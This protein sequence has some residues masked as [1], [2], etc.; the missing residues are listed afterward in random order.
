MLGSVLLSVMALLLPASPASAASE[1]RCYSYD[2]PP[3]THGPALHGDID[4]DER[5]DAV[6]TRAK[7]LDEQHCRAFLV[8]RT[9][10]DTLRAEVTSEFA[11]YAPPR[12]A[13]LI[14]LDRRRGLEI[15]LIPVVGASTWRIAVYALRAGRLVPLEGALFAH[16]GSVGNLTG[17]DCVRKRGSAVVSTSATYGPGRKYRVVR[18]FYA[19]HSHTFVLKF[20][21]RYRVPYGD[22]VFVQFPE[23][24]DNIHPFPS[25]TVVR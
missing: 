24:G 7:W 20:T 21:E 6:R 2:D 13:G 4:G 5:S 14:R 19:L 1:Q 8:V 23:L 11:L 15:A 9:A 10:E 12:L 22:D 17:V 16:G 18:R 25:C 3:A